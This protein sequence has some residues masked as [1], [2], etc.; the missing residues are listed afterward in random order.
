MVRAGYDRISNTYRSDDAD[1]GNYG[2]WLEELAPLIPP[3]GRVLDLGCG[4]GVPVARWLAAHGFEVDGVD[5]S[6]VQ[7]ERAERLVPA[8]TFA[9]VDMTALELPEASVDAIVAFYSLIHVPVAEHTS[10]LRQIAAWLRPGGHAMLIMGAGAWTGTEDDWYGAPMYWSH[11]DRETSLAWIAD[12]GL[13][14]VWD[15]HIPEDESGHTLVL[16][17]RPAA[18]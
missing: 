6:P 16:A 15:R 9:C 7:I 4:N 5:V 17:R 1:D 10:L 3:G 18:A 14:V 8:A 12:A 2:L 13:Q 11:A